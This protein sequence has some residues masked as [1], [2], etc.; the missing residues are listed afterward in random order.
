MVLVLLQVVCQ[1]A[2]DQDRELRRANITTNRCCDLPRAVVMAEPHGSSVVSPVFKT[3]AK[4][5][6]LPRICA[7]GQ[8][9]PKRAFAGPR[10]QHGLFSTTGE[11]GYKVSKLPSEPAKGMP[12][13]F[14][15]EFAG[16]YR[17]T[18]LSS[19]KMLLARAELG[20]ALQA[21]RE[22]RRAQRLLEQRRA[23]ALRIRKRKEARERRARIARK[24]R[25]AVTA[26]QAAFRGFLSRNRARI[27]LEL[28]RL[29]AAE[30][31]QHW[32][33][34]L[35]MMWAAAAELARRQL[36]L[37]QR[38]A[39]YRIECCYVFYRR[40][41]AATSILDG[42]KQARRAA[43]DQLM[44]EMMAANATRIQALQRG[45][46][47]RLVANEALERKNQELL[48]KL[49]E[50]QMRERIEHDLQKKEKEREKKAEEK[51][52]REAS[53]KKAREKKERLEKLQNT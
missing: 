15:K 26:I 30:K 32:V 17:D 52:A 31:I 9:L 50:E 7:P 23:K 40:R 33:R 44:Q 43:R 38:A 35:Y 37:L 28:A 39:V 3:Y 29:G 34:H 19:L 6:S 4:G 11:L 27:A 41:V 21:E 25:R 48:L 53:D 12:G 14:T 5:S 42:R 1:E 2:I 16:M 51:K 46:A 24:R 20:R 18:S 49:Q 36:L 47:G 22:E 10:A 8:S 45:L 13:G